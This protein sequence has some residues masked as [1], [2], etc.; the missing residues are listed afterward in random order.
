MLGVPREKFQSL[1]LICFGIMNEVDGE[2]RSIDFS[3]E[4]DMIIIDE[5]TGV[6]VL[7]FK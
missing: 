3:N 5:E 7:F 6:V 2:F 1:V 4:V